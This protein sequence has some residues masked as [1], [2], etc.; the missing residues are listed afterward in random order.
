M[1]MQSTEPA[2]RDA[3]ASG[4]LDTHMSG[5]LGRF[6][7]QGATEAG[8]KVA[9]VTVIVT[10]GTDGNPAFVL[11]RRASKLRNHSGQWAL[12]GGRL[13]PGESAIDAARREIAEE[14]GIRVAEDAVLGLL[15]DYVTRSG[16][17]ITPVVAWCP[18]GTAFRPSPDEVAE[19][20]L[21][22]LAE[23]ERPDS[24]QFV[25][26]P[27][28]DRPVVR[29]PIGESQIHAPTAAVLYQFREVALHGRSTRVAHLEQP[30]FAWR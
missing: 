28:S 27:E 30:V 16:Y 6:R 18:P 2:W 15:D 3:W 9:A 12:P 8:L 22:A 4:T 23:L 20:H 17:A 11:T 7:R 10:A 24:P 1:S 13:D 21:I 25:S 5:H 29:L 19:L 26:I 14:I